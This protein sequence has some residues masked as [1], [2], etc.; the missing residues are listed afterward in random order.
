MVVLS[1]YIEKGVEL[2]L[3]EVVEGVG[4]GEEGV[5][6]EGEWVV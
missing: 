6:E 3:E 5:V 1:G 2:R 4:E